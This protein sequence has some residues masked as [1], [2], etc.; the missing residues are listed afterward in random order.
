MAWSKLDDGMWSHPK[1]LGLSNAAVGVWAKAL[2]WT[3][4]QL[5]D[6]ALPKALKMVLRASDEDVAE[7]VEAG[8]WDEA[9]TGWQIHDYLEFNPSRESV[10]AERAKGRD[11]AQRSYQRRA[12]A[13][14]DSSPEDNPKD[15]ESSAILRQVFGD[16]STT[17]PV[18]SRPVPEEEDHTHNARE[19]SNE[20][21]PGELAD[22]VRLGFSRR[23]LK[24]QASAP[25]PLQLGKA[26]PLVVQ[27]LET[28]A[29]LR[30][31]SP[32]ALCDAVLDAFF[33]SSKASESRFR[34]GFLA[35][36]PGEWLDPPRPLAATRPGLAAAP[37]VNDRH[38]AM[39]RMAEDDEARRKRWNQPSQPEPT[40]PTFSDPED[41][42][43]FERLKAESKA[44]VA[45]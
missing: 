44:M 17:R 13:K 45:S 35:S 38:R 42:A 43:L 26:V 11:R 1:F 25:N 29:P 9:G 28:S 32:K 36:D 2:S 24:K 3:A 20:T 19:P 37:E 5:T 33:A 4:Q 41:Q 18:P 27:W 6:G 22:Y 40:G 39:L 7:L 12:E 16:S 8:L 34:P 21:F 30:A 10:L 15:A 23:Y 31:K 14:S